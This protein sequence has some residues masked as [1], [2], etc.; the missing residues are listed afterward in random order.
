MTTLSRFSG[1]R[2]A[3][4]QSSG[5][6][7]LQSDTLGTV[8]WNDNFS[9]WEAKTMVAL[10]K[11]VSVSLTPGDNKNDITP[12]E[13]FVAWARKHDARAYAAK[14]MVELAED[15]R[16]EDEEAKPITAE[17]FAR[18]VRLTEITQEAGGD[19][20]LWYDDDNIFAGHVI[21]VSVSAGRE[22]TEAQMMG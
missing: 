9:Y 2:P 3:V 1:E 21:V 12:G 13:A 5:T 17:S 19:G 22:F 7:P 11:K 18:R 10:G 20:T 8:T 4:L 6:K 16:D 14:Q 15:W